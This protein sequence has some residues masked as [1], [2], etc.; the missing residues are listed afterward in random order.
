[1][2]QGGATEGPQ[3]GQLQERHVFRPKSFNS[4]EGMVSANGQYKLIQEETGNLVIYDNNTPIWASGIRKT[5]PDD[6]IE[7][8]FNA[9]GALVQNLVVGSRKTKLFVAGFEDK[10]GMQLVLHDTGN[11]VIYRSGPQ[12]ASRAIWES[13]T[14]VGGP[15]RGDLNAR[16]H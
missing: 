1:M 10:R 12:Q 13:G 11:L 3:H 7:T 15:N 4:G 16:Q 5:N 8:R 9:N 14:F 6:V 2:R